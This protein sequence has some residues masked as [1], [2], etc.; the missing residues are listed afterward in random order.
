MESA[1]T[2]LEYTTITSPIEG[3]AGI[4]QIDLG[5]IIH[6]NDATPLV[7]LTQTQPSTVIFTLPESS[8]IRV[9]AA[10]SRGDVEV[11]ALDQNNA[12]V[13]ATGKLLLI[14]ALIDQS[15]ATIRLKAVFPNADERLW[16]G[17]F[18]N[19]SVLL[20]TEAKALTIPSAAVQRGPTGLFAWVIGARRQGADASRPGGPAASDEVT[21]I[22]TGLDPGERVV[23]E[24]Y[25]RLQPGVSVAIEPP[26]RRAAAATA[27]QGRAP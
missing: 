13:L 19:A 15:T 5:R 9:R 3:R 11:A 4:R 12:N 22:T 2:Q 6:A 26:T 10:M 23:T 14:D 17:E 18:V 8:S 7:T 21:I 24:G 25:Y 16:P 1:R 27:T 20:S